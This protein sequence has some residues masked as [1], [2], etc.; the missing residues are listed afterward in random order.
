[1]PTCI[2]LQRAPL[3]ITTGQTPEPVGHGP[4]KQTG[5]QPS[6]VAR[7]L[8]TTST[9]SDPPASLSRQ[10][11]S[12]LQHHSAVVHTN[13]ANKHVVPLWESKDKNQRQRPAPTSPRTCR[14]ARGSPGRRK[15]RGAGQGTVAD[16]AIT[17]RDTWYV[18]DIHIIYIFPA[19]FPG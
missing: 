19:V 17:P 15:G 6:R 5:G 10:F 3:T 2:G 12:S 11:H 16:E 1:M 9:F 4:S 14:Q 8:L 7:T 18:V 13:P